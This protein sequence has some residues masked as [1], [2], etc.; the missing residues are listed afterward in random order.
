MDKL[1]IVCPNCG[2]KLFRVEK[3]SKY[4][5]IYIWC[6]CCKKEIKVVEPRAKKL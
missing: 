4:D 1:Y 2:K 5:N 3:N 6:K